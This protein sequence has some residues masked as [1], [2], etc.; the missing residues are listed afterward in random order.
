VNG[1]AVPD[2]VANSYGVLVRHFFD[3]FFDK[4]SL[5]PQGDPEASLAQLLGL[6]AVPGAFFVLLFRPFGFVRWELV[7][8]RSFFVA[9]SM[10]VMGFI[11][12]FDWDALFP[13]R[14]DYQILTPLPI[15]LST[16][17]LAKVSALGVF[18]ALF[19]ADINGFSILFWPG[20]EGGS[21]FLTI[22]G[23]HA[24]VMVAGGLFSA[25]SIAALQGILI[26]FLRG[27]TYR[28]VSVS[29]QTALMSILVMLL[30]L[31]PL[32]AP[33]MRMLVKSHS[34]L[35]IYFPGFWFIGLYEML[36]PAAKDPALAALGSLGL[37]GLA[38]AAGVFVLTYLPGYRSHARRFLETPEPAPAG[39][40]RIRLVIRG[41]L[42]R[43]ILTSPVQRAVFYF[44]SETIPRSVKHRLFLATYGGFGVAL[45]VMHFSSGKSGLLQLPLT[46]S[47]ILV[48]GLRA[49]FNFPSELQ[50]NWA[51]QVSE[52]NHAGEYM[53]A[54][55]K[56]IV[57]CAI[58]PLF[59]LMAPM[60]FACFS[61]GVALF[62]LAFGIM[63]SVL[64]M[65]LMFVGFNKVPFTCA[66]FPGKV[67]LTGLS[68][69]Y[70]FGFT[71]YSRTMA[72]LESWLAGEPLA[73]AVFFGTA[74]AILL[75]AELLKRR[76][77]GSPVALDYEGA[78]DPVIRTLGLETHHHA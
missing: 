39:P 76:R 17:F 44:I 65:E 55:R 70:V 45:A 61:W 37:K 23:V 59:A 47:F 71:T 12:V 69:L 64:L 49:A 21:D 10:I 15:R 56:W 58:V 72:A 73:A 50:G 24:I 2:R 11:M 25:L 51:F 77:R 42:N 1:I 3:R 41:V 30:A 38:C 66:Y 75:L 20:V 57:L 33:S 8:A 78:G 32:I 60:E 13:D 74:G 34:P 6:L 40:G 63:L 35:L 18:L 31:T 29:V 48:S 22:M 4:E 16:L 68:A 27:K 9:F 19:L 14:R 5:S 28:R 52:V 53:A 36:R 62:H 46:L 7:S 26:T 67:N 54:M 43:A